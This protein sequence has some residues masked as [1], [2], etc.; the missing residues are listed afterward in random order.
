MTGPN[1]GAT[2]AKAALELLGV[3]TNRVVRAPLEAADQAD[4]ARLRDALV[5]TGLLD[6]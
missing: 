2:M 1:Y 6:R 4:V 5:A 3:T